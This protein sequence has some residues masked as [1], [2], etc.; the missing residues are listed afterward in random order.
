M[1]SFRQMQF[2][3]ENGTG[4]GV[5]HISNKPRV[6]TMPYL[7]DIAEGSIANHDSIF[8][9]GENDVVGTSAETL[10]KEGGLYD[11]AAVDAAAG[12]VTVSSSDA[13]DVATTGTGA[14]TVTIYGLNT[15]GV[16]ASESVN[17][18]G[19]TAVTS[20]G[21]YSRVNRIIVNTTGTTLSNE[22][23]I[24]VGTGTVTTG[25][26]AVVWALASANENQ[27]LMSIWTVPTGKTLYVV[28]IEVNTDGNK[29]A[30]I[31]MFVRPPGEVFQIK[32]RTHI[33][34]ASFY[35]EFAIPRVF[36]AGTDID[37]RAKSLSTTA[38]VGATFTGWYE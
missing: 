29:G 32:Y 21:S 6:S 37:M 5:K 38:G 27:T 22:G 10:W 20:S 3:D 2:E 12:Q 15:S 25:K 11:W 36:A 34:S 23:I 7:Y 33:F 35:R 24:Y 13:D 9:F 19:Q 14:R 16:A 17:M 26:P 18:N 1:S 8:K 30:Q 31:S 4:Y 28:S